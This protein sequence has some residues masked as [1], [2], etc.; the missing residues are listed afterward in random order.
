MGSF[1]SVT[2]GSDEPPRFIV[3]EYEAVAA[4]A[5]AAGAGR[6]GHH[7][8]HRRHLAQAGRR[9]G[10]DE[11]RHV[12]RGVGVR[13]VPRDRRAQGEDQPDRAGPRLREHAVG[14]R[15]Q[16]RRHRHQHVGSDDRGAQHRRRGPPDPRRR[17][18]LCRA[19]RARGR[20]RHRDADRRDGHRARP[21]RLRRCSA[22][23][24]R[25][26]ARCSPRA[27]TPTTA[28]GSCRCGTTTRRASTA[29]SPISRTSRDVPAAASPPRA[30]CRASPRNTTGRIST[31]RASPG[32]KARRRA[33]PAGRCRC[34][35]TWLLRRRP[36][37]HDARRR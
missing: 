11:V 17:A 37:R 34:S 27:T 20:R 8:R 6:Q 18:D 12:R 19:L 14:P 31:S 26:R 16:A 25:S 28:A 13:H 21:R 3:L 7:V 5:E 36:R 29:T 35:T 24:T 15:D 22:T 10:P 4:Q 1:L 2:N 33:R 9:H 30:S 23:T 32:R